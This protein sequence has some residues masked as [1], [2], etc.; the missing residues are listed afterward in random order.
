MSSVGRPIQVSSGIATNIRLL[1]P[2]FSTVIV[3]M[4]W[5][6][7][8]R[9]FISPIAAD[10]GLSVPLVGQIIALGALIVAAAGLF[11]GPV[12]DHYGH[13]RSIVI[14]LQLLAASA[15]TMAIAPNLFVMAIGGVIG[16]LGM[17]MTYGVA[18]AVVST[19]FTGDE[20]RHTVGMTQAAA[21]LAVLVGPPLLIGVA[22]LTNW[23]GSLLAMAGAIS[24]AGLL[25]AKLLPPDVKPEGTCAS[26]RRILTNYLPLLA[27]PQVRMLYI[28]SMLRSFTVGG[29]AVYLGAFYL[30]ILSFS[31]RE[32]AIA[33]M[34]EGAGQVI[35]N[36]AGGGRLGSFNPRHT[37]ALGT[38][39]IGVS[40]LTIYTIQPGPVLI[41]G[42]AMAIAFIAGV[43]FTSLTALLAQESPIAAATTMVLN[44]SMIAVGAALGGAL[45]GIILGAAGY[46]AV[47]ITAVILSLVA[48]VLVYRP[49]PSAADESE[50]VA[51][52]TTS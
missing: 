16:G 37:F 41:V 22:A 38:G 52:G 44:I 47:G 45:G 46:P 48:S 4:L 26:P 23:R 17:A 14:G 35:G 18:F 29:L 13:R 43:T 28:V 42:L 3:G 49:G 11:T 33:F 21:S 40:A 1:V 2:I 31:A 25:A 15:L 19:H 50:S 34:L 30:D 8:I 24:V 12:A 7:G 36:I 9:P 32:V 5:W 27:A 6:V 51:H 10:F 39:L 20:R